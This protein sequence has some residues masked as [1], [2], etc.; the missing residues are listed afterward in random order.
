MDVVEFTPMFNAGFHD[1]KL[2]DFE[3]IFVNAFQNCDRRKYLVGRFFA[4]LDDFSEFSLSAEIWIDGSF[5]TQKEEPGD[6]D[7]LFVVDEEE[8]N[9]L[10]EEKIKSLTRLFDR[11][12][13]KIRYHCDLFVILSNNTD[14][15][16][17]WRGWFGYTRN[18]E[19]KG[20][21]RINY[22]ANI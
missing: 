1:I 8:V 4:L 5:S 18:E 9:G 7:I 12:E 21:P 3:A 22:V 10:G 14:D 6:I 2:E 13:A 19:P 15:R 11:Q 17:Y 16:S 20:I